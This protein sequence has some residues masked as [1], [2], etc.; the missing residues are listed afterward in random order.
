MSR[1]AVCFTRM[2]ALACVVIIVHSVSRPAQGTTVTFTKIADTNTAIPGGTGNF[3]GWGTLSLG[4]GKAAFR[5]VGSDQQQGIYIFEDGTL[6]KFADTN[7]AIP[8]G[9]GNFTNFSPVSLDGENVAFAGGGE[10]ES[11]IYTD[12]GGALRKVA[13]TDTAIPDGA[14]NFTHFGPPSLDSGTV[15]FLGIGNEQRGIYTEGEGT[16]T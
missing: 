2:A 9:T 11:G 15:A 5:A 7:T 6:T 12:L 10:N 3:T 1:C 13:D 16:L 14:G 8:D 4:R